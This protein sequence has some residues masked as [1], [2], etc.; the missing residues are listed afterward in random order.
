MHVISAGLNNDAEIPVA[1]ELLEWAEL[2]FVMEKSHLTRLRRKFGK[3]MNK[4]TLI[5]LDIPDIYDFME[6]ALID[7]LSSKLQRFLGPPN[8]S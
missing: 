2:I 1:P 7:I 5:C 4:Q 6:P 8:I 3:F